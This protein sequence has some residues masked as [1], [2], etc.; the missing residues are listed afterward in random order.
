MLFRSNDDSLRHEINETFLINKFASEEEKLKLRPT[1]NNNEA[2]KYLLRD[3]NVEEFVGYSRLIDNY[4]YFKRRIVKENIDV[5]MKGLS[6]LMFVEISLDREK[7]DPQRIF[8]SLNST[9]LELTQADLIRNYILMGLKHNDQKKIYKDYWEIIEK[10]AREES[11]NTSRVS[12][13]I[14]DYLTLENKKIPN[15][16]KVYEEFKEKYPTSTVK[17]LEIGRASC[18]ERV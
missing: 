3:D 13:F 10:N 18:R 4:E 12:D 7:D 17:N 5:V 9:G 6:K 8:E 14:R 1:E 2:L 11:S 16:N 15:K